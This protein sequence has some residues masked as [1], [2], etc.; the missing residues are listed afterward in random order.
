MDSYAHSQMV[1]LDIPSGFYN[2]LLSLSSNGIFQDMPFIM[3]IS[4]TTN[5]LDSFLLG[6]WDSPEA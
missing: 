1:G 6:L 2:L 4:L 5:V 3:T